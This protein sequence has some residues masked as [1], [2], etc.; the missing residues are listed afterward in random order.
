MPIGFQ[1]FQLVL[2]VAMVAGLV[3]IVL[4]LARMAR[5]ARVPWPSAILV[6]VPLAGVVWLCLVAAAVNRVRPTPERV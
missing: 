5:H 4:P 3:V 1:D 2:A 6:L